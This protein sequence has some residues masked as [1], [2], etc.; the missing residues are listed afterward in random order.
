[1]LIRQDAFLIC[2]DTILLLCALGLLIP[3]VVFF[4][5]CVTALFWQPA[6][7]AEPEFSER[8]KRAVWVP[9]H[10]EVSCIR[11]TLDTLITQLQLQELKLDLNCN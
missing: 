9:A 6:D 5:E 3:S 7:V 10:N 1:M 8:S 2:L 11:A 4:I